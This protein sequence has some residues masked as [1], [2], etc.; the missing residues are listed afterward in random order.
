[1]LLFRKSGHF[2]LPYSALL[3]VLCVKTLASSSLQ[4]GSANHAFDHLG[5][6]GDQ[7]EAAAASGANIIYISGLG[8]AGYGGLPPAEEFNRARRRTA[9]YV[10][11]AKTSGIRL[12]IGY[13]CA[14]SIVKLK[15]FDRNWPEELRSQLKTSPDNWLQVD[16]SGKP[17]KSWYGGDYEP[18]CMNNPDWRGYERYIV[19]QQLEAGCDAIFFDNPTVH[20]NGC[21]CVHCM[22]AFQRFLNSP[23]ISSSSSSRDT[24]VDVPGLRSYAI[25]HPALFLRFR[26]TIARD[27]FAHIRAYARSLKPNALITANN[28]LNSAEVLFSQCRQ[29]AYNIFE[30]SKTE[31]Y[32]VVEDLSNQ[33]RIL[34][35]GQTI[36]YGSTYKQLTAISHGK[37][38]VAVTIADSDYHTAPSLVRLAMA[39]AVANG[40]SYLSWPT[41]PENERSR[42][43]STIRPQSDFLKAYAS[44][45]T[46]CRPRADVLVFLPFRQWVER[47]QCLASTLATG[48]SKANIQYA[49]I[50]EDQLSSPRAFRDFAGA[51][52]LLVGSRSDL[53]SSELEV[54]APLTKKGAVIEVRQTADLKSS[55]K[56]DWLQQ[57]RAALQAP[58]ISVEA[59]PTLRVVVQDQSNRTIVHLLNLN[60]QKLSSFTDKITPARNIRLSV[61]VPFKRV[62][63]VKALTADEEGSRG[64]LDF[65]ATR[66]AAG[67]AVS[68]IVPRTEISSLILIK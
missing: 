50:C 27:F 60:I 3:W 41:W 44:L 7:A 15:E 49:V 16:R 1:M 53:I 32:V 18:G 2:A 67:S 24:V 11:K 40:G 38:V 58:S 68:V 57:V 20:P 61:H 36:E 47:D 56:P 37:P 54:A 25:E 43:I 52:L 19:R 10:R 62:H 12:A 34:P 22:A 48:L 59:P 8:A 6:I 42:M 65:E 66:T 21:F 17:L 23:S 51:K 30:M 29:Y 9:E 63:S 13:V 35:N 55:L 45:L 4:L 64:Q 33:P 26:C 14:T 39:E 28:S 5:S 46:N 31:D